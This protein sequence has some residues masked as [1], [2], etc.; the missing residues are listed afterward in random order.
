MRKFL[1]LILVFATSTLG[2]M[3]QVFAEGGTTNSSTASKVSGVSNNSGISDASKGTN[4]QVQ[5]GNVKTKVVIFPNPTSGLVTVRVECESRNM[6]IQ[7]FCQNGRCVL[8]KKL[9][10]PADNLL[11][12]RDLEAGVYMYNILEN[13]KK[14]DAGKLIISK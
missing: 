7:L 5:Q 11:D 1:F 6:S 2:A 4:I 10:A 9:H 3:V 8:N 12:V 14:I 13:Y